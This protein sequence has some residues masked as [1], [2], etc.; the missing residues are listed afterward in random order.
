M[1]ADRYTEKSELNNSVSL[2]G[3]LSD[4]LDAHFLAPKV[5]VYGR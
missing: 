3:Y 4:E 1:E 5:E 2:P